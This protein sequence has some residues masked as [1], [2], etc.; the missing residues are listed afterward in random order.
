M[1]WKDI[2]ISLMATL[3]YSESQSILFKYIKFPLSFS[4]CDHLFLAKIVIHTI[5]RVAFKICF[6]PFSNE[7]T[8]GCVYQKV[9]LQ[10]EISYL[11]LKIGKTLKRQ[12]MYLIQHIV[13]QSPSQGMA[14]S[15]PYSKTSEAFSYSQGK[16]CQAFMC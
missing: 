13:F 7:E 3:N 12:R 11:K 4:Q 10:K 16:N 5:S 1:N 15:G 8:L 9:C 2:S 14:H 6:T